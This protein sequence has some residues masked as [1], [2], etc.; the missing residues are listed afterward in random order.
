[1]VT[2]PSTLRSE[3]TPGWAGGPDEVLERRAPRVVWL[4]AESLGDADPALAAHPDLPVVFVF[5]EP[6]LAGLRLSGK[7]LVFLAQALAGIGTHREL[8]VHRGR[9][10]EVLATRDPAVTFT[11]VPGWRAHS[12][13]LHPAVIHPWAWLRRPDGGSVAGFSAWN[14]RHERRDADAVEPPAQPELF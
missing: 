14:R 1:M 10:V 7:R 8:E 9:P 3:R 6:L 2:P 5:D 12:R 4:T 13:A 11:P